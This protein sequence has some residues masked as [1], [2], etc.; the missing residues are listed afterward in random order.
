MNFNFSGRPP[1]EHDQKEDLG[2]DREGLTED[3]HPQGLRLVSLCVIRACVSSM[4]SRGTYCTRPIPAF[5]SPRKS[6]GRELAI[7]SLRA[8]SSEIHSDFER[9]FQ[10]NQS[11]EFLSF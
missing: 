10:N 1:T 7:R 11:R 8:S 4:R 2:A 3:S 6:V 5:S 9:G